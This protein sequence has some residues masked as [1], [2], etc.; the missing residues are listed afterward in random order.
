MTTA[1]VLLVIDCKIGNCEFTLVL[2]MPEFAEAAKGVSV[3][4]EVFDD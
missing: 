1:N 4:R 3:W 2:L